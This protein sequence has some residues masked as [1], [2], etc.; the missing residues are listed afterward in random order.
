MYKI[1]HNATS[2][3]AHQS[4]SYDNLGTDRFLWL[5]IFLEELRPDKYGIYGRWFDCPAETKT[6]GQT[7]ALLLH[8]CLEGIK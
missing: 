1:D 6:S 3:K 7:F 4:G 8:F 5:Q 2:K